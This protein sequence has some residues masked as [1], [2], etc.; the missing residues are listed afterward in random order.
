MKMD[1]IERDC[2]GEP[3]T[4]EPSTDHSTSQEREKPRTVGAILALLKAEPDYAYFCKT[5]SAFAD[6]LQV[7]DARDDISLDK[8]IQTR[9]RFSRH[10]ANLDYSAAVTARHVR[11]LNA[12]LKRAEDNGWDPDENM[13]P[14]WRRLLAKAKSLHCEDVL[15]DFD[16]D[17]TPPATVTV[18]LIHG[19][20]DTQVIEREHTFIAAKRRASRFFRLLRDSDFLQLPNPNPRYAERYGIALKQFPSPMK[21]ETKAVVAARVNGPD[22]TEDEDL[23]GTWEEDSRRRQGKK[24]RPAKAIRPTSTKLFISAVCRL[25]GYV[26]RILKE[27]KVVSLQQLFTQ[28]HFEKFLEYLKARNVAPNSI[29]IVFL[30]IASAIRLSG[31][32]DEKDFQ[33][34]PGFVASLPQPSEED[35]EVWRSRNHLDYSILEQVPKKIERDREIIAAR[36]TITKGAPMFSSDKVKVYSARLLMRS[37][38]IRW[39]LLLPWRAINIANC[40]IGRNLDRVHYDPFSRVRAPQWVIDEGTKNSNTTFWAYY[41]SPEETKNGYSV[42]GFVPKPLVDP[43]NTFVD[44]GYRRLLV[45]RKRIASLFVSDHK[46]ELSY[47]NLSA[48]FAQLS[49]EYGRKRLSP[50]CFRSIFAFEYIQDRRADYRILSQCL[51]HHDLFTTLIYL[52][53][54]NLSCANDIV[55]SWHQERLSREGLTPGELNDLAPTY[56]ED[57]PLAP[58]FGKRPSFASRKFS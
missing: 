51:W 40:Q 23:T 8:V 11:T 44:D 28:D 7:P 56:L 42:A 22:A 9:R 36:K 57:Q 4:P 27:E 3:I 53:R 14:A 10:L 13:S 50:H 1:V 29:R 43:L 24:T 46:S 48:I 12:A 52:S 47:A 30:P 45:G 2:A 31:K 55:D 39:V 17:H 5:F 49:L 37:L 19:W 26:R 33:W 15:R 32:F 18:D 54:F 34:L 16:H 6:Y 25:C 58:I 21:K 35:L 41:F 20:V 38:L